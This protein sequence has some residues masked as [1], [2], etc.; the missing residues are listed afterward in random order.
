MTDK[1]PGR[2]S[3][4]TV[5]TT[6]NYFINYCQLGIAVKS[7]LLC[8]SPTKRILKTHWK[9]ANFETMASW[10]TFDPAILPPIKPF[11]VFS[12]RLLRA[13]MQIVACNVITLINGDN[14][15]DTLETKLLILLNI[16]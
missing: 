10:C 16:L 5:S 11:L 1:K 14:D 6:V 8:Y 9:T 2:N 3:E 4:K 15:L 12:E 7:S 13:S